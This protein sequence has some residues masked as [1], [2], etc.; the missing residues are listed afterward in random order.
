MTFDFY[1]LCD[2]VSR[3]NVN[4]PLVVAALFNVSRCTYFTAN[5]IKKIF[6]GGNIIQASLK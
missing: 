3:K 2:N 4:D 6:K 5:L 1:I